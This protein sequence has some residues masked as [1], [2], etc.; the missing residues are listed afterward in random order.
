MPAWL[1]GDVTLLEE[2][3]FCVLGLLLTLAERE[4]DSELEDLEDKG[5][6]ATV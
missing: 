2:E 1:V 5:L 3:P 4:G 6:T